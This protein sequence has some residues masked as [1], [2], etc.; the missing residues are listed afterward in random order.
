MTYSVAVIDTNVVV[1]GLLT[2]N[3]DA[4][5]ARILDGMRRGSF[6]FLLSTALL[7]EYREVLTRQKIRLLHGLTERE[8]DVLLTALATSAIVREPEARSG[9]PDVKDNHLWSLL[10]S[11]TGS[12]LVTGDL[13]LAKNPPAGSAV[14]S[15]RDFLGM[16]PN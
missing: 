11:E 7:A 2:S 15:A 13:E 16:I 14:T 5:T 10:Q 1:A 3:A 8:V 4:P 12:V 6:R 9:A